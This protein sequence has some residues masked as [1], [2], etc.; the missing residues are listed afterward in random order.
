MDK[1]DKIDWH[2]ISGSKYATANVAEF[3]SPQFAVF[4]LHNRQQQN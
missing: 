4:I 2:I 3:P 1:I